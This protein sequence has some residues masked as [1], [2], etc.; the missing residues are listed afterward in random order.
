MIE[1]FD[2]IRK[3]YRFGRPCE[4]LAPYVEFFSESCAGTTTLHL[5]GQPFSVRMFSSYTPTIWI[6]LG[7]AYQLRINNHQQRIIAGQDILVVRDGITERINQAGDHIF[8]IKFF[9]GGLQAVLGLSQQAMAGR[10]IS[11]RD[12]LPGMFIAR[13]KALPDFEQRLA[14]VQQFL[15]HTLLQRPQPDHYLSLVL[16]TI[17]D[18]DA[19]GMHYHVGEAAER[20]F[21]T[22][23]TINRYF[24]RVIGVSPKQYLVIMRARLALTQY[25][26][27]R[28]TFDP[29]Q[30]GYYD[31][32]H[33]HKEAAKFTGQRLGNLH[34]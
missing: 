34:G 26:Q 10:V 28:T 2:D 3:I 14:C 7:P 4:A 29:T 8:T 30:F 16:R 21:V 20:R 17:A 22:S 13:L 19:G 31:A 23:R 6:N 18:H 33:F 9:P 1:I 32:S 12:I 15:L 5:E 25:V 27:N 11:L 24:N